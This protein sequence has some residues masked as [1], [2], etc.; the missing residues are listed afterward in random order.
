MEERRR[1]DFG[2]KRWK[3][4]I[5]LHSRGCSMKLLASPS[6]TSCRWKFSAGDVS[7]IFVF[8]PRL[9]TATFFPS[10]TL[11]LLSLQFSS[12]DQRSYVISENLMQSP[13]SFLLLAF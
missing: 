1:S 4:V 6:M 7:M 3:T 13:V 11:A 8:L 12:W 10:I 5:H 9:V 2:G